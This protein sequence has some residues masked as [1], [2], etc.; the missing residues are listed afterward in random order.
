MT[1]QRT[2]GRHISSDKTASG[3][4]HLDA[5][6]TFTDSVLS[7]PHDSSH[8]ARI[9]SCGLVAWSRYVSQGRLTWATGTR[10]SCHAHRDRW[11]SSLRGPSPQ[12]LTLSRG[13]R[14]IVWC[15]RRSYLGKC[16]RGQSHFW[17]CWSCLGYGPAPGQLKKALC[18]TRSVGGTYDK[19]YVLLDVANTS[20]GLQLQLLTK[21]NIR[22][23]SLL[24]RNSYLKPDN[25]A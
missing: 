9:G 8:A 13:A 6:W 1:S 14:Y 20:A 17:G 11:S 16:R 2:F 15:L 19:Y 23:W 24:N 12:A 18:H 21:V 3:R 10:H 22:K 7:E 25:W 5:E 4:V